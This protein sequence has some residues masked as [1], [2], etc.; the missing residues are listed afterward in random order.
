M[1][2]LFYWQRRSCIAQARRRRDTVQQAGIDVEGRM[3]ISEAVPLISPVT[4]PLKAPGKPPRAR[5]KSADGTWHG[6]R[7]GIP[8]ARRAAPAGFVSS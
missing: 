7:Y 1:R 4:S 5:I 6:A 3:R 8:V 2:L